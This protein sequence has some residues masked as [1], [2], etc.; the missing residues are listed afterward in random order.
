MASP[1]LVRKQVPAGAG[2]HWQC[3][4][5]G[6]PPWPPLV[7]TS[8]CPSHVPQASLELESP[9]PLL[10]TAHWMPRPPA[11][12]CHPFW[13]HLP[14]PKVP[15]SKPLHS[16]PGAP[17]LA[18]APQPKAGGRSQFPATLWLLGS[19]QDH[20]TLGPSACLSPQQTPRAN[21]GPGAV[22]GPGNPPTVPSAPWR[23]GWVEAPQPRADARPLADSAGLLPPESP[24]SAA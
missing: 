13:P 20:V 17:S 1:W 2:V 19:D 12:P 24:Q 23:W 8:L 9:H 21:A 6:P 5:A 15:A 18:P 7:P 4:P 10:L 3:C 16:L 14:V 11:G 22:L